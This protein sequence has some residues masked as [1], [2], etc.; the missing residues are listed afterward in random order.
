MTEAPDTARTND[1]ALH[2]KAVEEARR[3]KRDDRIAPGDARR[4][5]QASLVLT[6]LLVALSLSGLWP[7]A[8]AWSRGTSGAWLQLAL[9]TL[10]VFWCGWPLLARFWRSL[11][12]RHPDMFTLIGLGVSISYGFSAFVVLLPERVP[13]AFRVST[14]AELHFVSAAVIVT[15]ALLE[16]AIEGSV[17]VR[18]DADRDPVWLVLAV[19]AIAGGAGIGWMLIGPEPRLA[20][21]LIAGIATLVVASPRAL[22]LATPLA[23]RVAM[24]R[25]ERDGIVFSGPEMIERL[26]GLDTVLLDR[27]GALVERKPELTTVIPVSGVPEAELLRFAASLEQ[28]SHHPFAAAIVE[29]ANRRGLKLGKN[30]GFE[31]RPGLGV[32]GVVQLRKVAVGQSVVFVSIDEVPLG[33][34]GLTDGL[35]ESAWDAVQALRGQGI[36]VL[37]LSGD[38]EFTVRTIAEQLG[39]EEWHSGV[40]LEEKAAIVTRL[41]EEGRCVAVAGHAMDDATTLA[42]ADVAVAVGADGS[43]EAAAVMLRERD[44]RALPTAVRLSEQ[45]VTIARQ[46]LVFAY[47]YNVLGVSIATGL[48]YSL[49]GFQLVPALAATAMCASVAAVIFNSLRLR[50]MKP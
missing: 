26:N 46:N 35:R 36:R 48:L 25:A 14:G 9:A 29:V 23:M 21:A 10:V 22:G 39:I 7:S 16:Q 27:T 37:L 41:R 18:A 45:A 31:H 32:T 34:L 13:E 17:P 15:L 30:S 47:A 43:S 20:H 12:A 28:A 6:V 8:P 24:G 38:H 49:M 11:T 42:A 1:V 44:L 3:D 4:R 50:R 5:F 33:L 2:E 40:L 19:I